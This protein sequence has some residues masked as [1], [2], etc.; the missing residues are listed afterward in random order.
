MKFNS[1]SDVRDHFKKE[2]RDW[3]L[4]YQQRHAGESIYGVTFH[5]D[6]DAN[7]PSYLAF[8][9]EAFAA[10]TQ[11]SGDG[12]FAMWFTIPWRWDVVE[13]NDPRPEFRVPNR[14]VSPEEIQALTDEMAERDR[15]RE[16][17][18]ARPGNSF[19]LYRKE[20]LKAMAEALAALDAE[21]LFGVG[22]ERDQ[23]TL[24]I[25]MSDSPLAGLIDRES[26]AR[27]NPWRS[28][29]RLTF[30]GPLALNCLMATYYIFRYLVRGRIIPR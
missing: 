4:E 15:F 28:A 6:D 13:W 3:Y 25:S 18:C 1:F 26:A 22:R 16:E 5:T 8:T 19:E 17:W 14:E 11:P 10:T 24:F 23:I 27:L 2:A 12:L 20:S 7:S 21:G 29:R 30:G 9:N